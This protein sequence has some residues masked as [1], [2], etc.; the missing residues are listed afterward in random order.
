MSYSLARDFGIKMK[1]NETGIIVACLENLEKT[2]EEH[3]DVQS[4][5]TGAWDLLT[6]PYELITGH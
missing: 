1:R 6:V 2:S 3:I 4:R 5:K